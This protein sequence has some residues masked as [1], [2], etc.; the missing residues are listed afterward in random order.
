MTSD[1]IERLRAEIVSK[2]D[3]LQK[4]YRWHHLLTE[5]FAAEK[6]AM[7]RDLR[8]VQAERDEAR[9]MVCGLDADLMEDQIEY[10]K[11]RG[12]DCFKENKR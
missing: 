4:Q 9:R 8:K 12:W 5:A 3:E 1:E 10:G 6:E 7:V 11:R 2:A